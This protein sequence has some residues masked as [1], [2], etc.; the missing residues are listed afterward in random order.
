MH[1]L[2]FHCA[3]ACITSCGL[4]VGWGRDVSAYARSHVLFLGV[5][6]R[7]ICSPPEETLL[8]RGTTAS[9]EEANTG[10]PLPSLQRLGAGKATQR[11]TTTACTLPPPTHPPTRTHA[12]KREIEIKT[13]KQRRPHHHRHSDT[14]TH[15]QAHQTAFAFCFLSVF[16]IRFIAL[17]P[18]STV[19]IAYHSYASALS[20]SCFAVV[21]DGA[22]RLTSAIHTLVSLS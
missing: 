4:G 2:V 11:T 14:H 10:A 16:F 3:P 12:R 6:H 22:A 19:L 17:C 15:T 5:T 21:V 8:R 18:F 7:L 1:F 20:C 9:A 13:E